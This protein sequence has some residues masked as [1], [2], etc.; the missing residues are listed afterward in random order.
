MTKDI[1]LEKTQEIFGKKYDYSLVPDN[2]RTKEKIR[3]ICPK[4]G[5]F[6]KTF[7]KHIGNKQGCPECSGRKRYTTEYFI[8][9]SQNI[10]PCKRL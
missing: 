4:H 8:K 6:Y 2:F 9:K 5:I 1:L 10:R 3:I 7:E